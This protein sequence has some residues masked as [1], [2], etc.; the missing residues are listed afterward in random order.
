[1]VKTSGAGNSRSQTQSSSTLSAYA[2]ATEN[3]QR[4]LQYTLAS[5][6]SVHHNKQRDSPLFSFLTKELRARIFTFALRGY[7][8]RT[9]TYRDDGHIKRPY[10]QHPILIDLSLL[11]TCRLIY[12]ETHLLA[13]SVQEP[14]FWC[15]NGPDREGFSSEAPEA[16]FERLTREQ[17]KAVH[18]VRL[19]TQ[20]WWLEGEEFASLCKNEAFRPHRLKIIIRHSDWWYWEDDNPLNLVR[21]WGNH[22]R[23]VRGLREVV[24]ELETI[25]RERSKL[26]AIAHT[27]QSW[28]FPASGDRRFSPVQ[29][30]LKSTKRM[31]SAGFWLDDSESGIWYNTDGQC[32]QLVGSEGADEDKLK[33]GLE[34]ISIFI[35]WVATSK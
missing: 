12:L 19:F 34:Y 18:T 22:L 11:Q 17:R 31:G 3:L 33:A 2:R 5:K 32:W 9:Q 16:F 15:E 6:V 1:M 20:M 27:A 25:S 30:P 26:F 21:V 23:N 35:R 7:Y 10:Y 14:T 4:Q 8:D 29:T 24:L 13:V 28:V